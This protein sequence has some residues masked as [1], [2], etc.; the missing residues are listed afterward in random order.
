MSTL[1][2]IR[3]SLMQRVRDAAGSGAFYL[4]VEHALEELLARAEAG[5]QVTIDADEMFP[6]QEDREMLEAA[7]NEA[8]AK[9]KAKRNADGDDNS[10]G[11]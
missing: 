10:S 8:L 9:R 1:L 2:R 4:I 5:D 11:S 3:P 7:T 6:T